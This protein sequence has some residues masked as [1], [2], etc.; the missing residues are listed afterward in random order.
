MEVISKMQ[1]SIVFNITNN[2]TSGNLD[3]YYLIHNQ[4]TLILL[5]RPNSSEPWNLRPL[6]KQ[7]AVSGYLS[8]TNIR[9]GQYAFGIGLQ[10]YLTLKTKEKQ[11]SFNIYPNPS[12]DKFVIDIN[13]ILKFLI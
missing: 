8:T 2:G 13:Q 7:V 11:Q 5:Y 1:K 3:N 6:Q 10:T 12:N 4:Q 9:P